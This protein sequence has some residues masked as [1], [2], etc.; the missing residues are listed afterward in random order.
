MFYASKFLAETEVN[1]DHIDEEFEEVQIN[2][3]SFNL[4]IIRINYLGFDIKQQYY[5]TVI[6]GFILIMIISYADDE[7]MGE[8][9][10]SVNPMVLE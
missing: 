4:M 8:P 3:I 9:E 7:Q 5:F 2:G 1:Y 10:E 6:N